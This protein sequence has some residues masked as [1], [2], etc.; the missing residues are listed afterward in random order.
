MTTTIKTPAVRTGATVHV[1]SNGQRWSYMAKEDRPAGWTRLTAVRRNPAMPSGWECAD[2][3][4]MS[5]DEAV[6][7]FN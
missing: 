6:E 4:L 7:V 3:S 2:I 5:C 1:I